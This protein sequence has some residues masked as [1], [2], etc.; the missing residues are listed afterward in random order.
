M[1]TI[2][3]DEPSP[4]VAEMFKQASRKAGASKAAERHLTGVARPGG[5]TTCK[6]LCRGVMSERFHSVGFST[7]VL[8]RL[9]LLPSG[10]GVEGLVGGWPTCGGTGALMR[11]RGFVI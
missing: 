8:V 7:S 11:K 9:V 1:S 5:A 2:A 3:C 10:T 6:T 4:V